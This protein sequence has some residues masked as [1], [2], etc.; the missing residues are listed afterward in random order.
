MPVD[1]ALTRS[2][3]SSPVTMRY[4]RTE[5]VSPLGLPEAP[6]AIPGASLEG[7]PGF[8]HVPAGMKPI[9]LVKP[10][11]RSQPE[12][13]VDD[14]EVGRQDRQTAKSGCTAPLL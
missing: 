2:P 11:F 9:F 12:A 6:A 7:P 10:A 5:Q 3:E 14:V 13:Q 8:K 1:A 4:S